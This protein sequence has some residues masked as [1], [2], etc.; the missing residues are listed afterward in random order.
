MSKN[1]RNIGVGLLLA[2]MLAACSTTG[3][4]SGISTTFEEY[5]ILCDFKPIFNG[6][7]ASKLPS[8]TI[9][10]LNKVVEEYEVACLND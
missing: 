6:I 4:V 9:Q 8:E 3:Q 7:E 1:L 2:A 10:Y 5:S